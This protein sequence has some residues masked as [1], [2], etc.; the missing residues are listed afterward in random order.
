[1]IWD[2][3]TRVA[4]QDFAKTLPSLDLILLQ[5]L[6]TP[7]MITFYKNTD[8]DN[9]SKN[10]QSNFNVMNLLKDEKTSPQLKNSATPS[11]RWNQISLNAYFGF[12]LN[13]ILVSNKI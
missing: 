13:V 5:S 2:K 1:M 12:K 10:V 9:N 8:D 11:V 3:C 4:C 6:S 7:F